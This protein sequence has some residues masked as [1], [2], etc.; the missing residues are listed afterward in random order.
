VLLVA[1]PVLIDFQYGQVNMLI[2]AA[3]VWALLRH[4]DQSSSRAQDF[5][6]WMFAGIAA[7]AKLFPLPLL[8]I[9]FFVTSFQKEKLSSKK[10]WTERAG[11][12]LGVALAVLI[13]VL[14]VGWSGWWSLMQQWRVALV[15]R[16]FPLESHNQSFAAFLQHYTS[17]APTEIIAQH[18]RTLSMGY[19][20]FSSNTIQLLAAAWSFFFA[21][22]ILTWILAKPRS[23][24]L[25][26]QAWRER[27]IAVIVGLLVLPSHLVWKPYFIMGLPAAFMAVHYWNRR[28]PWLFIIALFMNFSGFDFLGQEWGA[29][30][31][32][33]SIM[34]WCHLALLLAS[35][36]R[37]DATMS[38]S[39]P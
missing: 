2:L 24:D 18:R 15:D 1:R 4:S 14:H 39:R 26:S 34:L 38:E 16:G 19:A 23:I 8:V 28:W 33:A 9:P 20:I 27:W 37:S 35:F 6:S 3:C 22:S 10:L 25:R 11:L 12:V 36:T 13:P 5:L 21:G 31:E 17:G 29:R 7:I 30:A 32:A